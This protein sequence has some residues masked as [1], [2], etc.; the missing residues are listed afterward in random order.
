LKDAVQQCAH[1]LTLRAGACCLSR[2]HPLGQHLPNIRSL[3]VRPGNLHEA[4]FVL[5]LLFMQVGGMQGVQPQ[6]H[7]MHGC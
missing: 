1:A 6:V 4:M 5:P 2:A 7:A 3:C